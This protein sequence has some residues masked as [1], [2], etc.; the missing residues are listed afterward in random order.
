MPV[1]FERLWRECV[2]EPLALARAENA[3][4][5]ASDQARRPDVKVIVVLIAAALAMTGKRYSTDANPTDWLAALLGWLHLDPLSTA[6]AEARERPGGDHFIGLVLWA[7]GSLIC[8]FVF[9]VLIIRLVFREPLSAYGVKARGAFRDF[10]IYALMLLV[11]APLLWFAS[12]RS[13]FQASYPFFVPQPG[14]PL[15]PRFWVWETLYWMQFF[16]LEFF[17]RGF[18]VHGLK[19]RFGAYAIFV[20]VVPYCMIHFRKPLL[21]TLAS[22]VAGTVLGFMSLKTRSVWLGTFVHVSVA[23]T[24]DLVMLWHRGYFG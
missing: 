9:P 15:W 3:A 14:E 19:H 11:M 13:A 22:I 4:Y 16:A 6:L 20:M 18:L 8:Y 1:F 17:F 21:E 7:S 24:V 23:L 2:V 12:H 5:L 10:W